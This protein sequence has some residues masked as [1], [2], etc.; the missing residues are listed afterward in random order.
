MTRRYRP[1]ARVV[2]LR[3]ARPRVRRPVPRHGLRDAL[4]ALAFRSRSARADAASRTGRRRSERRRRRPRPD[5]CAWTSSEAQDQAKRA[6]AWLGACEGAIGESSF[7]ACTVNAHL[8]Y[9]C[10]LTPA[11]RPRGSVDAFWA[12]LATVQSCGDVDRCVFPGGVQ[13]C[14]AVPTGSTSACGTALNDT[15]ARRVRR[16]GGSRARR[17]ALRDARQDV[18]AR[19]HLGR[20]VLGQARVRVHQERVLGDVPRR[21]QSRRRAHARIA[22]STAPAIGAGKC[23]EGDAGPYCAPGTGTTACTKESAPKCDGNFVVDTCV[24]GANLRI[25]CSR[26][27]LPCDVSQLHVDRPD[28]RVRRSRAA[29][30]ARRASDTC[31]GDTVLRSCGRGAVLRGRLRERGP[32]QVRGQHRRPRR[33]RQT[34]EVST[35]PKHSYVTRRSER[36]LELR[37]LEL[38][39]RLLRL[40]VDLAAALAALGGLRRLRRRRGG[41]LRSG[42]LPGGT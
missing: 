41:L 10:G 16:P 12:C 24:G 26:L 3:R 30:H 22:G 34:G 20:D 15:R 32:R 17:R 27:G 1:R 8:A 2:Q 40:V 37:L 28:R 14:V 13:D 38:V 18:L 7:G 36:A 42:R 21:L 4:H 19:G 9:D 23:V 33:V 5:F 31:A 6:C 25:D 35:G 29:G 11:L 39:E